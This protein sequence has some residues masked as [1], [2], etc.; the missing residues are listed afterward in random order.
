MRT[1]RSSWTLS[2]GLILSLAAWLAAG[3]RSAPAAGGA[4]AVAEQAVR[5]TT[6]APPVARRSP[7]VDL[8]HGVEVVDDYRW[9]EDGDDPAVQAWS[10]A[11]AAY[12]RS[13]LDRLPGVEELRRQL[14][15]VRK[16]EVPRYSRAVYAGGELYVMKT[17]PPRQ[18]AVL[19]AMRSEDDPASARVIVDPTALDPAG[20]TAID[21]FVPSADGARVAVSLSKAGSE[22]GDVHV[23]ESATGRASGEVV[24]R[25]QYG[26]AGGSLAWDADGQG[27]YYTRYPR[28][29]ERPPAD[30][31][32]YVQVYYHRLGTPEAADRYELGKGFP[33]IAEIGLKRSPDGRYLLANVQN[34]D[35]GEFEQHL[36]LSSGRW[37]R[38]TSFSDRVV[39]AVFGP[40]DTLYLLSRADAPRGK[41]LRASLEEVVERGRLDLARA[42]VVVPESD[43]VIEF[44][45]YTQGMGD[46]ITV[47]DSRLFVVEGIGGPHRVRVFDLDGEPLGALPLPAASAVRQVI[48]VGREARDEVLYQAGSYTEPAAWSRWSPATGEAVRTGLTV[49]YPVDFSDVEAASEWAVSRD[50]TR[51]PLTVLRRRG[52]R[53]DGGNPTLLIGYGG[54]GVSMTPGFDPGLRVWLDHGGVF[55]IAALRG[56]GEFGEEWHRAGMLTQKQNVFDD[57]IA[58][59]EHLVRAGYTRRERLAIEGGSNGGLLM[60]A[61][62]T[63]RP[64][65]FEA[66]ISHAGI[67]DMLRFELEPNG[68]FNVPELGTVKDPEQFRALYAY[69]P[70]HRVRDGVAYPAVMLLT[71]AN[72]P[73]VDPLHSRKLAARLQA[74]GARTVLLRTSAKT[75]HG[76]GT[77]L[78][79][80]IEQE[81]DVLAFLFDQ[82]QMRPVRPTPSP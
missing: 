66:V 31:D 14:A 16:I 72:D 71:G 3:C 57:F 9:L 45:F 47:T 53:L 81:V 76:A 24:H 19:V 65:L 73:R 52:V 6:G 69:S 10:D 39:H 78:D 2:L 60:G 17:E 79:A 21:W 48:R 27:F 4:S 11:Q 54:Y 33:R 55:A 67:Y 36:R 43:G 15:A 68:V 75:G 35:S 37:I 74:A 5:S 20:S 58:C 34:G 63:Q 29:G 82:L 59:A 77:P 1:Q 18:Q 50:G 42:A 22:R 40:H 64:D 38:L 44:N 8:Y 25:V 80:A 46:T 30:L 32:F 28:E 61:M 13:V 23:F 62:L 70:Y 7:V 51:V 41:L 26:T 12:A 56:G 49:L